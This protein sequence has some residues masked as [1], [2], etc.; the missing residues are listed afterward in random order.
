[1]AVSRAR[2]VERSRRAGSL[3]ACRPVWLGFRTTF[4]RA[5]TSPW[6][7]SKEE[8]ERYKI[9]GIGRARHGP[10]PSAGTG[11]GEI[12]MVAV[13]IGV[14]PHEASHTAVAINAAEEPLAELRVRA[15]ACQ[16]ERLL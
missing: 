12:P 8:R 6:R 15:S 5:G 16:A 1:M 14:D 7:G 4:P 2:S 11:E 13:M 9:P 10:Y 3:T